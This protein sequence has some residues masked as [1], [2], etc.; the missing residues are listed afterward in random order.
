MEE[1]VFKRLFESFASRTVLALF[2]LLGTGITI[3]AFLQEKKVDLRYE[4][5]A[6]TNVLDFNADISKLEVLYDSTNLKQTKENLRIYTVKVINNGD[7]NIINEFYDSNEPLGI[8]LNTGKII[9]K[10]QIIETSNDYIKRNLKVTDYQ[11]DRIS[12]SQV[13]IE[14]GEYFIVKL[15]VLHNKETTPNIVSFGKIAGQKNINVVNAI[16]VKDETSFW[17]KTYL[18]NIWVQLLRLISYFIVGV[19]IILSIVFISEQIDT[20]RNKKRRLKM[21]S[22]FKNLKAYQYTRMDDAIFDRYK[23][24]DSRRFQEMQALIENEKTLNDTYKELTEKLKSKEYKRF[25][26]IESDNK[27]INYMDRDDFSIINEMINDGIVFKE[28]EKLVV[29][30][31][32]KDTLNKFV[33]FLKERGEF[34]RQDYEPISRLTIDDQLTYEEPTQG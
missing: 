13:I 17:S 18:G 30:Q 14:S 19:L 5:I 22:E 6:N 11:K 15:L 10:P 29:N 12:F 24:K 23:L 2:G 32:M 27:F 25:R 31:A 3:Y 4:V 9:E 34:K 1:N 21:I 8:R 28:N 20:Y 26:R 33:N 7:Q 16:D